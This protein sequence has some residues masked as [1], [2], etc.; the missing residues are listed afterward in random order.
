MQGKIFS[1]KQTIVSNERVSVE[2]E[3]TVHE[4]RR[5][6]CFVANSNVSTKVSLLKNRLAGDVKAH[7][8]DILYFG[9][10]WIKMPLELHQ[11]SA[12]ENHFWNVSTLKSLFVSFHIF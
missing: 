5:N 12:D 9:Y 2:R 6:N 10:L 7:N 11:V 8:Q 1:M 4:C 3:S